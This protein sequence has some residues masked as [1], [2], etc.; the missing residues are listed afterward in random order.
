[1]TETTI[2]PLNKHE[3]EFIDCFSEFYELRGR[4][5]ALGLVFGTLF[6]RSLTPDKGMTQK[7][8]ATLITKSKS[9]VSRML[10]LLVDQGFC[11]YNLEENELIRAE[12]RYFI[13]SS[14]RE[15]TIS[16][17]RKSIV[18]NNLLKN[19]LQNIKDN[20]SGETID[21]NHD[22]LMQISQFSDLINL[23]NLAE[24]NTLNLLTKHYQ[25]D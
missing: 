2:I 19:N 15:I 14:F 8:I 5:E 16:R 9:T 22:L 21:Q 10:D 3:K 18:E 23:L 20:V 25:D 6:L 11:S 17:T 12:R 4:S 13:K 7:D 24:E 1:M